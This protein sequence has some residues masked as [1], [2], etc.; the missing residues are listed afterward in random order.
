MWVHEYER[1]PLLWTSGTAGTSLVLKISGAAALFIS[2]VIAKLGSAQ[3]LAA[4][5]KWQIGPPTHLWLVKVRNFEKG[6]LEEGYLH[7]FLRN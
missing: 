2:V 6:P 1:D 3:L 4:M 7:N 5:A